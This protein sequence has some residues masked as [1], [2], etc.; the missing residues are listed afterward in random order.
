[1]RKR[2]VRFLTPVKRIAIPVYG[3]VDTSEVWP[4]IDTQAFQR[5]RRIK[6]LGIAD[7]VFPGAVHTRFEHMIGA[8]EQCRKYAQ[9]LVRKGMLSQE[10]GFACEVAALLHDVG[11]GPYSHLIEDVLRVSKSRFKSHNEHTA[12]VIKELL[13]AA[14]IASGADPELVLDIVNKKNPLSQLV[15]HKTIG[16]DK[17]AY[18]TV[19]QHHTGYPASPLMTADL[20]KNLIFRRGVLGTD[21]RMKENLV[22]LQRFYFTMYSEVYLRKQ[23]NAVQRVFERA[24]Q[25]ALD[26]GAIH[27]DNVWQMTDDQLVAGLTAIEGPWKRAAN[28]LF[29]GH[30]NL[31]KAA[32]VLRPPSEEGKEIVVGKP[33]RTLAL[34]SGK[35]F[36]HYADPRN[37][38]RAEKAL[39][40]RFK[41]GLEEVGFCRVPAPSKL[42]PQDVQLFDPL[43]NQTM[44]LFEKYP[45]HRQSMEELASEV[46]AFRVIVAEKH[47]KMFSEAAEQVCDILYR[48]AGI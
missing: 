10:E 47:R 25:L 8:Y 19:D 39:A 6:Q 12:H 30:R 35:L 41:V 42:V 13:S 1:M 14:I 38:L 40:D 2:M 7:M 3:P 11:H 44:T 27:A 34:A 16:A 46:T 20:A 22:A 48:E 37:V 33:I 18:I 15:S 31:L 43:G 36:E 17:V 26:A 32:V 9:E 29:F 5:M 4:I 28:E 21:E 45:K 23:I 24:V